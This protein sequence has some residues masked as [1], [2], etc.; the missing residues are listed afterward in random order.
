M[1]I[2]KTRG[3]ILIDCLCRVA[4]FC[5][6]SN[7][8]YGDVVQHC[9]RAHFKMRIYRP[10]APSHVLRFMKRK[11]QS[12]TETYILCLLTM[13]VKLKEMIVHFC[14]FTS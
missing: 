9:K 1:L 11:R 8:V 4:L 6:T 13:H 10:I 5:L 3:V 2:E 14:F 7:A 12:H